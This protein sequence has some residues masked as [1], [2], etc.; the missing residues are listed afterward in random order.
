[1][2]SMSSVRGKGNEEMRVWRERRRAWECST[3]RRFRPQSAAVV[4]CKLVSFCAHHPPILHCFPATF[5]GL[6]L[7][8]F[9]FFIFFYFVFGVPQL[10]LWGS[11]LLGEIF[12]YVTVF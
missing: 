8:I 2:G 12:A 11:P 10:Y 5:D 9:L 3:K 1:M 6:L 7:T 4:L